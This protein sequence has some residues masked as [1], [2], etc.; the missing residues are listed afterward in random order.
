[1]ILNITYAK[2]GSY[3]V[4]GAQKNILERVYMY[5]LL[6]LVQANPNQLQLLSNSIIVGMTMLKR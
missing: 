5:V 4:N 3:Y 6:I 2:H 1:M